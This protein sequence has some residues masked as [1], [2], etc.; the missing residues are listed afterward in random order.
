MIN[1]PLLTKR[2]A[3]HEAGHCVIAYLIHRPITEVKIFVN[4]FNKKGHITYDASPDGRTVRRCIEESALISCAGNA[5][6]YLLT[7]RKYWSRSTWDYINATNDLS[8]IYGCTDEIVACLNFLWI[9]AMSLLAEPENWYALKCLAES[10]EYAQQE[11]GYWSEGEY[12]INFDY[13]DTFQMDGFE[14]ERI[15]SRELER[16]FPHEEGL[17]N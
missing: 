10:I 11:P 7:G 3:F 12:C 17:S 4:K 9:R 5:A 8:W 1:K 14:V 16:Y 6:E 13:E 15:I 2:I